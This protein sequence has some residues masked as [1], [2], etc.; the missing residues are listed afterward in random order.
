MR[1]LTRVLMYVLLSS[2]LIMRVTAE[3]RL[4]IQ[5]KPTSS[6]L[7]MYNSR[8]M[9]NTELRQQMMR[10]L[11]TA[12][13]SALSS[14]VGYQVTQLKPIA[15]GSHVVVIHANLSSTQR[16]Q[17]LDNL[18]KQS[19]I[20]HVEIDKLLTPNSEPNP[21][22]WDFMKNESL[23]IFGGTHGDNF[24]EAMQIWRNKY[25]NQDIGHN[26]VVAVIDTGYTPH[27][28][29]VSGLIPY[30]GNNCV[31]QNGVGQCYGYQFISDCRVAGSCAADSTSNTFLSPQPDGLDLGDFISQSDKQ[32]GFFRNCRATDSTWHGSHVTGTIVANG[33]NGTSGILG[34][35]Y[36]ARVLPLRVLG[37]CG[38]FNSDVI[39]A[40][41][42]AVNDYPGIPNPHPADVVNMS[43]GGTGACNSSDMMQVAI[44]NA[45][46]HNAVVVVSAGN[47]TS[48]ITNFSP[49]GCS[50]V[51][52]V[53]AKGIYNELAEYS[54]FGNTTMTAS[55]GDPVQPILQTPLNWILSTVWSSTESYN[56]ADGSAFAFY[57]GTSMAAPHVSAAVADIIALLK[58]ESKTYDNTTLLSI[59]Q[60]TASF[61]YLNGSASN[62]G[63]GVTS[64]M[65]DVGAAFNYIESETVLHVLTPSLNNVN[66]SGNSSI[67]VSFTNNDNTEVTVE[68]AELLLIS[69]VQITQDGCSQRTLQPGESCS[70]ILVSR[71]STSG[72]NEGSLRLLESNT[73]LA[74][75]A[76]TY[77]DPVPAASAS[78]GGCSAIDSGNDMSMFLVLLLLSLYYCQLRFRYMMRLKDNQEL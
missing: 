49:A 75:V 13:L 53:A 62:S 72:V 27:E 15:N 29:I 12:T 39:D 57:V 1:L 65:L 34:G 36:G 59:L 37:K 22:Q 46:A 52:S 43:L 74:T 9:T 41:Y 20:Q 16:Q 60:N 18:A 32:T 73:T 8:Q 28:N 24:I 51:F 54:N 33:F 10:P 42:Y 31:S 76:I 21:V 78:G 66:L 44:N 45:I 26:A 11:S 67:V 2:L 69:K 19:N 56:Y 68:S 50:G 64:G 71:A 17:L 77:T 14:V 70:I 63:G 55:G 38:G 35:A 25:P 47:E 7:S 48:N 6:Q 23:P 61:D 58:A 30:T 40:I 3:E 5:Y 4:I